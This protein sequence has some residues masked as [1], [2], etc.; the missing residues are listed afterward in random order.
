[1]LVQTGWYDLL[2]GSSIGQY[3]RLAAR[4][5]DVRLTVGPWTHATFATKGL[6]MVLAESA[7]F[8]RAASG[9]TPPLATPRVR[10]LDARSGAEQAGRLV[11]AR[12]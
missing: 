12:E 3:E 6:G 4:G 7:D 1:M 2:L 11:A 8:L 9:L 5:A 10:L